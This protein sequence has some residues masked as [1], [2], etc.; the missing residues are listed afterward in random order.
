MRRMIPLC[1]LVCLCHFTTIAQTPQTPAWSNWF[2]P[3][4][5]LKGLKARVKMVGIN[6]FTK[7]NSKYMWVFSIANSYNQTITFDLNLLSSQ[8]YAALQGG[9]KKGLEGF[10]GRIEVKANQSYDWGGFEIL[11]PTAEV[12]NVYLYI[13]NLRFGDDDISAPFSKDDCG[14][15]TGEDP[16]PAT[17]NSNDNNSSS[18][19]TQNNN[20]TNNSHTNNS[21]SQTTQNHN[22]AQPGTNYNQQQNLAAQQRQQQLQQQLEQQRQQQ[23]AILDGQMQAQSQKY[24]AIQSGI[25]DL[26]DLFLNTNFQNSI[27]QQ[28]A[29]RD[30]RFEE[31]RNDVNTKHG[32]LVNCSECNGQGYTFCDKCNAEGYTICSYCNGNGKI[33]CSNCSGTGVAFGARCFSCNGTG[34]AKCNYCFGKGKNVCIDCYGIGRVYCYRCRGTGKEFDENL[35]T[36]SDYENYA[37]PSY[38]NAPVSGLYAGMTQTLTGLYYIIE[39]NGNGDK[40]AKGQ[41][42]KVQYSSA[43]VDGTT[44]DNKPAFEFVI[45][46]NSVPKGFEEGVLLMNT[47]SKARLIVPPGLGYGNNAAGSM[48]ANSTVIFDIEL[49]NISGNTYDVVGAFSE[50]LA[51][52]AQKNKWGFIDEN[53]KEVVAPKYDCVS[54]FLNGVARVG[55]TGTGS[56]TLSG[57]I[58]KTGKVVMPVKYNL[59][60]SCGNSKTLIY[61]TLNGKWGFF[62][63]LK[64]KETTD[65]LYDKAYNASEDGFTLVKLNGKSG[66]VDYNGKEIIAPKYDVITTKAGGHLYDNDTRGM[67]LVKANGKWGAINVHSGNIDIPLVYDSLHFFNDW[68]IFTVKQE[69]KWGIIDTMGK[70]IILSKYDEIF[71]FQTWGKLYVVDGVLQDNKYDGVTDGMLKAK[72]NGLWG[73]FDRTTG[74][75]IVPCKYQDMGEIIRD[76]LLNVK[77]QN[78]WGYINMQD[79]EVIPCIYDGAWNFQK[80][81]ALVIKDSMMG[82]INTVGKVIIPLKNYNCIYTYIMEFSPNGLR[83]FNNQN[84]I[85][86]L[87]RKGNELIWDNNGKQVTIGY[88]EI[89]QYLDGYE[90]IEFKIY[91]PKFKEI[92]FNKTGRLVDKF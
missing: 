82:M 13:R 11:L 44:I 36:G 32:S 3:S 62:D 92:R 29:N 49:L 58:D 89:L 22:T 1:L 38:S 85:K 63:V 87:Q 50:G 12:K 64:D 47:G 46:S 37:T 54:N 23:L 75:E 14:H 26:V 84:Y 27:N 48:P 31:L 35:H 16:P 68:N 7:G 28:N 76:G 88:N 53:G 2:Y 90:R 10:V 56:D 6:D 21:P 20:A 25:G 74:K 15:Y 19:V 80:G 30:A 67:V 40:P 5:C 60:G 34:A 72:L 78:K 51:A 81:V 43:L 42:V 91:Y 45:G 8:G 55:N 17:N 24:S 61:Y 66:L 69:D 79:K 86:L 4:S 33:Q 18:Q 57:L 9:Q 52:V 71:F 70:E 73:V 59:L 83:L 41:K 77:L 65:K 39:K